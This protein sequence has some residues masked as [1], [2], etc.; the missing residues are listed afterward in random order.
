MTTLHTCRQLWLCENPSCAE[1]DTAALDG[2]LHSGDRTINIGRAQTL[3]G[4]FGGQNAADDMRLIEDNMR[5]AEG[6]L[7]DLTL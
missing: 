6:Q 5:L 2:R 3:D 7:H 4:M 1:Q